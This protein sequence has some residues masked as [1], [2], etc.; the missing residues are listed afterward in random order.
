MPET[1]EQFAQRAIDEM[2]KELPAEK[3]LEGCRSRNVWRGC[4]PRSV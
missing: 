4:L 3:R 1:L 2:L